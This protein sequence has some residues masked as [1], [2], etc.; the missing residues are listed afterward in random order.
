MTYGA[1][2][3]HLSCCSYFGNREAPQLWVQTVGGEITA[4]PLTKP[5]NRATT[6][7]SN[8]FIVAHHSGPLHRTLQLGHGVWLLSQNRLRRFLGGC[9]FTV[10]HHE[11][12]VPQEFVRARHFDTGASVSFDSS[13]TVTGPTTSLAIQSWTGNAYRLGSVVSLLH[14]P[15]DYALSYAATIGANPSGQGTAVKSKQQLIRSKVAS[16]ASGYIGSTNWVTGSVTCNL[17]VSSVIQEAYAGTF[18]TAPEVDRVHKIVIPVPSQCFTS[19]NLQPLFSITAKIPA[20]AADWGT[21]TTNLP[22]FPVVAGGSDQAMAGDILATGNRHVANNPNGTGHV[23]VVAQSGI[24]PDLSTD[25]NA[26]LGG[27]NRASLLGRTLSGNPLRKRDHYP[28]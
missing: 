8:A 15:I 13:G 4:M 6:T 3:C 28:N 16:V 14:P 22:C 17:F 26:R 19:W 11:K 25:P 21:P 27:N 23:G 24:R 10:L 18:L 9:R 20:L 5:D 1:A 7:P 12:A 2:R